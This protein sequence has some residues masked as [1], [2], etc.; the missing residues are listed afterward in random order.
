MP[1]VERRTKSTASKRE[2]TTAGV[3]DQVRIG[4]NQTRQPWSHQRRHRYVRADQV[5]GMGLIYW[6]EKPRT[7]PSADLTVGY[8]RQICC[9]LEPYPFNYDRCGSR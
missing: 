3:T 2:G 8:R 4:L 9:D 6:E 1:I 5:I 7:P